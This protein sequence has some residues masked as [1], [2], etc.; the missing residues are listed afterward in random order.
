[1]IQPTMGGT[2]R[3]A[4]GLL[5]LA[6]VTSAGSAALTSSLGLMGVGTLARRQIGGAV[7]AGNDGLP[8]CIHLD[9]A[10]P[11]LTGKVVSE[12]PK[13]APDASRGC[14]PLAANRHVS[15][16]ISRLVLGPRPLAITYSTQRS[17]EAISGRSER[18]GLVGADT[19]SRTMVPPPDPR[20]VMHIP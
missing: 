6:R 20:Q 14:V 4:G 2:C 10:Q 13:R 7:P 17:R 8:G 19:D 15:S 18:E 1:M 11:L 5:R 12:A 9:L 3:R 16:Q